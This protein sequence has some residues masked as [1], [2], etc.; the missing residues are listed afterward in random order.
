MAELAS[1]V[2]VYAVDLPGFGL[3]DKPAE[4]LD[5]AGL[6]DALAAW[7]RAAGLERPTLLANSVGCQIAVDCAVRHPTMSAAWC[8]SARQPT[9]PPARLSGR[10]CAGCAT[11]PA[12]CR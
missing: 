6:A 1:T 2:E 4:P 10:C 8:W 11:S 5:V 9:R 12:S 7:I 3:T